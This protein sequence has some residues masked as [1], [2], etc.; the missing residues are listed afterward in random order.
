MIEF[1]SFRFTVSGKA[2]ETWKGEAVYKDNDGQ[3]AGTA[4]LANGEITVEEDECTVTFRLLDR[5]LIASDNKNCGGL[6]VTFDGA[7]IRIK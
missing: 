2:G 1:Y 4:K 5:Y 7:Y 6:N 3:F